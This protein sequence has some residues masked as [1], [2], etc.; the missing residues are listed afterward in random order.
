MSIA[1]AA[2]TPTGTKFRTL[3][4]RLTAEIEQKRGPMT[5]NATHKRL[6][7]YYSRLYDADQLASAQK[8]LY[9]LADGHDEGTLPLSLVAIKTKAEVL[10]LMR[11]AGE[12]VGDRIITTARYSNTTPLGV[13]LQEFVASL[14]TPEDAAA[15]I[16]LE[17]QRQ[18]QLAMD[19]IR[20]ADMPGFFPTP[21]TLAAQVAQLANIMPGHSVLEPSAGLGDLADAVKTAEPNANV[22]C[23]EIRPS[24]REILR[25][26]G[27]TVIGSDFMADDWFLDPEYKGPRVGSFDR[28]VMNPPF[29]NGQDGE[30]VQRAYNVL[31]PGGH[32]VAIM[33]TGPFFRTDRKAQTFQAFINEHGYDQLPVPA[34]AFQGAEA[35]R[36]TG[37]QCCIVIMQRHR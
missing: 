4:D 9:A 16:A 20:F 3:A 33:S 25:L 31:K 1:T 5:Q 7:E 18:L 6:R 19:A 27:H 8:G 21:R 29:E 15:K 13:A 28:V 17:Q 34:G 14:A 36:T 22:F 32:L 24:L 2:R 30:H 26:K 11:L 10:D 37:V 35:F 23:I 12:H